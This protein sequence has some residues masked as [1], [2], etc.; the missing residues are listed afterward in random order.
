MRK[1]V[2]GI[3]QRGDAGGQPKYCLD[4]ARDASLDANRRRSVIDMTAPPMYDICA[5]LEP[6][7]ITDLVCAV[8][9]LRA[10]QGARRMV[11]QRSDTLTTSD[12]EMRRNRR[13]PAGLRRRMAVCCVTPP[14]HISPLICHRRRSLHPAIRR[15][16]AVLSV[17][18]PDGLRVTARGDGRQNACGRSQRTQSLLFG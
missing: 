17:I 11:Y 12:A 14:Q 10:G 3:I 16:N 6:I 2:N 9:R 15:A 7:L 18:A 5:N 13:R 1:A 8:R 4:P